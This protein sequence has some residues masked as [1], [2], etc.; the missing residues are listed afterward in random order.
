MF[1]QREKVL[2][3][4]LFFFYA[5]FVFGSTFSIAVA[6]VSLGLSLILFIFVSIVKRYNPF[7]RTVKWFYLFIGLYIFWMLVTAL[8]GKTPY[9]SAFIIKEEWL[10]CAVPIGIY[11]LRKEA[12][13]KKIIT[14]FAVGVGLFSLY[15]ILQHFTGIYWPKKEPPLPAYDFGYIVKGTLPHSLT[16]GNYYGT[17][18]AFFS[19]YLLMGIK[20]LSKREKIFI[21]TASALA[22]LA[23]I[24]SYSR[25][26]ILGLLICFIVLGIVLGKKALLYSLGIIVVIAVTVT[27]T[28]SGLGDH[29]RT[30]TEK[31]LN[32][33]NPAGRIFIWNNTL[34]I[35]KKNPVFGVGQGNFKVEYARNLGEDIPAYRK[36]AHAHNDLLNIAAVAGLPGMLFFGGIWGAAFVYFWAGFRNK[37]QFSGRNHFFGAAFLGS[38]MFFISSATEATFADE[39][40]RQM[41]MFVWAVGLYRWYKPIKHSDRY[42]YPARECKSS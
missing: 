15:G 40:V 28:Y 11:L 42:R 27:A 36:Y 22:V 26:P 13:R 6:Q 21:G 33:N 38:L 9:R 3:D 12:Y 29:I 14:A 37:G 2:N 4:F 8:L 24:F 39:E 23:T 34:K 25:G 10:F 35:I 31:E 5:L 20:G 32:L 30:S 17:A 19:A 18:A 41:L 16:F 7:P 1:H